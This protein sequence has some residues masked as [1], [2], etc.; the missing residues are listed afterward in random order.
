MFEE[1]F[2]DRV[3]ESTQTL[4]KCYLIHTQ[5]SLRK[6]S[7]LILDK[8]IIVII[9]QFYMSSRDRWLRESSTGTSNHLPTILNNFLC[10]TQSAGSKSKGKK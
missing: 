2:C 9:D 10:G 6:G 8:I 1:G 7:M 3:G 5:S 4:N